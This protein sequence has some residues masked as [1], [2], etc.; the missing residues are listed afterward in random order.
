MDPPKHDGHRK[1]NN[2]GRIESGTPGTVH[3][4]Y[5]LLRN[6]G[7][8]FYVKLKSEFRIRMH[9]DQYRYGAR[10]CMDSYGKIVDPEANF[11]AKNL[12]LLFA[13]NI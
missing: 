12:T 9:M 6:E 5:I 10:I 2:N 3:I 8:E 1:K 11:K 13:Y 7:L 4:L